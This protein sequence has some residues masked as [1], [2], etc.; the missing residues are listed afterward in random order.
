M[1]G[2]SIASG[3]S[4][5]LA[6]GTLATGLANRTMLTDTSRT[7]QQVKTDLLGTSERISKDSGRDQSAILGGIDQF[8]EISGETKVGENLIGSLTR[9]ADAVGATDDELTEMGKA[10][11]TT[12]AAFRT[13]G[14][15]LEEAQKSTEEAFLSFAKMSAI[16]AIS[17]GDL[18]DQLPA[19]I[20]AS[21]RMG[22]N[23]EENLNN[24]IAM[25]NIAVSTAAKGPAE[26]AEA[27]KSIM[28]DVVKHEKEF[29]KLGVETLNKDGSIRDIR[30]IIT[31]TA[32][33]SKGHL[34]KTTKLYGETGGKMSDFAMEIARKGN[35]EGKSDDEITKDIE[36]QMNRFVKQKLTDKEVEDAVKFA[37][38]DEAR[39][40]QK[41]LQDLE[42][43]VSEQVLPVLVNN[44]L[45][46][47]VEMTPQIAMITK[48]VAKFVSWFAANPISGL[49]AI[50]LA[51]VVKDLAAAAI[52]KGVS[53]ALETMLTGGTGGGLAKAGTVAA[54]GVGVLGTVGVAAIG[55]AVGVAIGKAITDYLDSET[56]DRENKRQVASSGALSTGSGTS[57][58]EKKKALAVTEQSIR[59]QEE[60]QSS[61]LDNGTDNLRRVFNFFRKNNDQL[62]DTSEQ[63]LVDSKEERQIILERI[64]RQ[65][66]EIM[67]E[68]IKAT[69]AHTAEIIAQTEKLKS[70]TTTGKNPR[71]PGSGS[72]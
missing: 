61:T 68:K 63:A 50:V 69:E 19:L 42:R 2:A 20:A 29:K 40:F 28:S 12:F 24:V 38:E 32:V 26:A 46:A 21:S 66:I 44:L 30:K 17:L 14:M 49:G 45:P 55:L 25:A 51:S 34:G 35:A 23:K 57:L 18:A 27:A 47:F 11:G 59:D 67:Q 70:N 48:E 41:A 6:T 7:R 52:G 53:T 22:G 8:S 1:G 71:P 16:G 33:K 54:G 60:Y 5:R 56:K 72:H 39:K 43:V 3:V 10:A 15:D 65:E 13:G 62:D 64:N 58:E 9:I 4:K 36:D 37:R 31:E